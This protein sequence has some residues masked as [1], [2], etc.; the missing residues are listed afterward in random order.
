[1]NDEEM[2]STQE[3]LPTEVLSDTT[4]ELLTCDTGLSTPHFD[5]TDAAFGQDP[6]TDPGISQ[7]PLPDPDSDPAAPFGASAEERLE[8]LRGELNTLRRELAARDA[9]FGRIGGECEEFRSLYPDTPLSAIPDSVWESVRGGIPIAAAYAL[10]EKKRQLTE[11]K[12]S[13]INLENAKRST[14]SLERTET[15][16]FSPTEVRAMTP[17]Q[18]RDNYQKIMLSMQKWH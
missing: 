12:A 13:Q 9:F 8:L 1:M 15:S 2:A 3:E 14:G 10:A 7:D 6:D 4:A 11:E 5:N 17:R 18:V 16:Y